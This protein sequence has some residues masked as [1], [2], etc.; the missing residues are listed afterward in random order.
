LAT[1]FAVLATFTTGI[2]VVIISVFLLAAVAL[3]VKEVSGFALL[4]AG[5]VAKNVFK[6][7]AV[8]LSAGTLSRLKPLRTLVTLCVSVV[9]LSVLVFEVIGTVKAAVTPY[10][11]RFDA[12]FFMESD[13][14][15]GFDYN[16]LIKTEILSEIDGV[17][18]VGFYNES[19][20]WLL[21]GKNI[22]INVFGVDSVETLK[23]LK[24]TPVSDTAAKNWEKILA[25]GLVPIIITE[26]LS[27][28]KEN[29]AAAFPIYKVGDTVELFNKNPD[30]SFENTG[31][32]Y[33]F[34]VAGIVKDA[35]EY[36]KLGYAPYFATESVDKTATF[37]IKKKDG[38]SD[39]EIFRGVQTII[40]SLSTKEQGLIYVLPYDD[41][42]YQ[43]AAELKAIGDLMDVFRYA[44]FVIGLL[45]ILNITFVTI[46]S[47][48]REMKVYS[49]CGMT[50]EDS[51]L[52]SLTEGAL[53]S[54][55]ALAVSLVTAIAMS[56]ALPVF[57]S[58]IEKNIIVPI[59]PFSALSFSLIVGGILTAAF[60]V[61]SFIHKLKL[62]KTRINAV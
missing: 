21:N 45:G 24:T 33:K 44:L 13:S 59:L 47:R 32:R 62:S 53:A 5:I 1:L 49:V 14:E 39:Q 51:V 37:L 12:D 35:T 42:A 2:G 7:H 19:G 11:T 8:S 40:A 27:L 18:T 22:D 52:L 6:T 20:G 60:V 57:S 28:T 50:G 23:N 41:Y 9:I 25:E 43:G 17:E 4:G 31:K 54:L 15:L 36:D 58:L 16:D 48:A 30:F 10:F 3:F 38:A 26:D 61:F 55:A 34:V 46:A 29:G 56:R